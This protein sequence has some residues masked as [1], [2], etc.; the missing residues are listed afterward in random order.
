MD[1]LLHRKLDERFG[2]A[3]YVL[4][5]PLL[6]PVGWSLSRY[7]FYLTR[8]FFARHQ[9]ELCTEQSRRQFSSFSQG[10]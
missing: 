8:S 2:L 6:Y 9:A 7:V 10:A 5:C 4:L 1:S 3:H